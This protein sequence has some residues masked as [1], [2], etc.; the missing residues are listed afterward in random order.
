MCTVRPN[1][2][3]HLFLCTS[4][5]QFSTCPLKYRCLF[6]ACPCPQWLQLFR[7]QRRVLPRLIRMAL[8]CEFI[9]HYDCCQ[10][11]QFLS[12]LFFGDRKTVVYFNP[13]VLAQMARP[14]DVIGQ[15]PESFEN[16]PSYYFTP[17]ES[18]HI[19]IPAG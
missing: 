14:F 12:W 19:L 5:G 17:V 13:S 10:G 3:Q 2:K 18:N 7:G 16:Y 8:Q 6:V 9:E 15:R 4:V 1:H 11:L